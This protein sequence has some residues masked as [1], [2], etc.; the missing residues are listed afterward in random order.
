MNIIIFC[1]TC[2]TVGLVTLS[3]LWHV[4][5]YVMWHGTNKTW[6]G[7]LRAR[8]YNTSGD[9]R[10]ACCHLLACSMLLA[11]MAG[12]RTLLTV[13][14]FIY[15]L[16]MHKIKSQLTFTDLINVIWDNYLLILKSTL[17]LSVFLTVSPTFLA[18]IY[19]YT[20]L[21]NKSYY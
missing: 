15:S 8:G 9:K 5:L 20:L 21:Y 18:N 7:T 6:P 4:R 17:L 14:E 10:C 11:L 16:G 19:I 12:R 1:R 3:D 2:E 13:K